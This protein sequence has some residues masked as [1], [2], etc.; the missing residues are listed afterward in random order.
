MSELWHVLSDDGQIW[1][2]DG[3]GEERTVLGRGVSIDI[4]V[5]TAFQY[6]CTGVDR[7]EF[8]CISMPCWPGDEEATFTEGPWTPTAPGS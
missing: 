2:R 1:R 8:L 4:P 3:T 7:L 5:G 6:R